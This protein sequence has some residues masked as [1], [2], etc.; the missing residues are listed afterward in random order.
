MVIRM[1]AN[2]AYFIL[3]IQTYTWLRAFM[4][5]LI[6]SDN[7]LE[8]SIHPLDNR[9]CKLHYACGLYIAAAASEKRAAC[10]AIRR[11]P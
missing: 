10:N 5:K 1:R 2:D 9:R 4:W 6:L 7:N 11:H 3:Y 8:L